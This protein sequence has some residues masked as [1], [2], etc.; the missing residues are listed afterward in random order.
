ME[1]T[2]HALV[3]NS[4]GAKPQ[5]TPV[6]LSPLQ[7][8]EVLVQIHATGICHADLACM[9]GTLSVQFPNVLGHEGRLYTGMG[10][11]IVDDS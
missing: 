1:G 8:N 7:S 5:L 6:A 4:A 10:N 2:T 3:V 11:N 9:G